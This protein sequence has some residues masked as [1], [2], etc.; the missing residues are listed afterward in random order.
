MQA[1]QLPVDEVEA[2]HAGPRRAQEVL[3]L[4]RPSHAAQGD[5]MI[6]GST[7]IIKERRY[8]LC[9]CRSGVLIVGS[10]EII[11]ERRYRLC[12]CRSGV[13]IVGSTEIIKER[14][15]RLCRCRSG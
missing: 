8:R 9:R 13:L 1:A 3:P 2:Q 6:V 12:R 4:V 11:K 5:A 10:T 15:Y 14:R 7:E